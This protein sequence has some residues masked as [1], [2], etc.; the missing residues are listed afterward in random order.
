[1]LKHWIKVG[2]Y[3]I[4]KKYH[5][6][7]V[8]VAATHAPFTPLQPPKSP[9]KESDK[10]EIS[11]SK[12]PNYNYEYSFK[13]SPNNPS[14]QTASPSNDQSISSTTLEK[15]ERIKALLSS[16]NAGNPSPPPSE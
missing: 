5:S 7:S 8:S 6:S 14:P 4:D 1:M 2:N 16:V 13:K 12:M 10:S 9:Y 11:G 3:W 15:M